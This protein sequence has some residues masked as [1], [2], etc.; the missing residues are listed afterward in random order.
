M[1]W[2]NISAILSR[3]AKE[4]TPALIGLECFFFTINNEFLGIKAKGLTSSLK[5]IKKIE[6]LYPTI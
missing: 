4:N 3:S 6:R 1:F 5:I 2:K